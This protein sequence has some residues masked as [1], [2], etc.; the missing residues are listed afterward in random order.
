MIFKNTKIWVIPK[1]KKCWEHAEDKRPSFADIEN[2]LNSHY[3]K[4][5][6]GTY[7]DWYQPSQNFTSHL[8][9][10]VFLKNALVFTIS[11]KFINSKEGKMPVGK[12]KIV[13]NKQYVYKK[14]SLISKV[15]K[16]ISD[17]LWLDVEKWMNRFENLFL[18]KIW[19]I[20][21][22]CFRTKI[23][24][25]RIWRSSWCDQ[26]GSLWTHGIKAKATRKLSGTCKWWAF[27]WNSPW[28]YFDKY[29]KHHNQIWKTN[30]KYQTCIG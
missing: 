29:Q 22:Q 3:R 28:I 15:F 6:S 19:L 4:I 7:K 2:F 23:T 27:R 26:R 1:P 5:A 11:K 18:K 10:I 24:Q 25:F 14:H 20:Y 16:T 17:S 8:T 13:F 12:N 9:H 21:H 30:G